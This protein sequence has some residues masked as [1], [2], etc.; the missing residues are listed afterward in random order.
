MKKYLSLILM[1]LAGIAN[2]CF[3]ESNH[4]VQ[5][6]HDNYCIQAVKI[7]TQDALYIPLCPTPKPKFSA[8]LKW[9][10]HNTKFIADVCQS[11]PFRV[12]KGCYSG[13]FSL[14]NEM[15]GESNIET[16]NDSSA[17]A[18]MLKQDASEVRWYLTFYIDKNCHNF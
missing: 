9:M 7:M 1:V 4:N 2:I 13:P 18:L 5:T 8:H 12:R 11:T 17:C 3:A 10:A 14:K 6:A 16:M 15:R